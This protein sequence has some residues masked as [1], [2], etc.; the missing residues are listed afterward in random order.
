MFGKT[1]A[2]DLGAP[3][4]VRATIAA[5]RIFRSASLVAGA[6][7]PSAAI[8][9]LYKEY[10]VGFAV[11]LRWSP[12]MHIASGDVPEHLFVLVGFLGFSVIWAEGDYAL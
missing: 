3:L 12:V 7:H 8:L 10:V 6:G 11:P 9:S 1:G 2:F 4:L 5:G